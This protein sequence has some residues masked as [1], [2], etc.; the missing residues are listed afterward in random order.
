[1]LTNEERLGNAHVDVPETWPAERVSRIHVCRVGTE[2]GDASDWIDKARVKQRR[3][4]GSRK[5]SI[6]E[7]IGNTCGGKC[8]RSRPRNARGSSRIEGIG[9]DRQSI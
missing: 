4:R 2:V 9:T 8:R 7:V 5:W 3:A 1:M 6:Y